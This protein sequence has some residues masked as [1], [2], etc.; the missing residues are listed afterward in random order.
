MPIGY[1]ATVV[2]LTT[3]TLFALIPP[4]PKHSSPSNLSY[5]LGFLINELPFIALFWL[6]FS[7]IL[8]F[9]QGDISSPGSWAVV[10]LAILTTGGLLLIAKRGNQAVPVIKKALNDGLVDGWRSSINDEI[11]SGFRNRRPIG[12]IVFA[13]F[14]VR[15]FRVKRRAN[16]R[17]GDAGKR[18]LLD[19][20][21]HKSTPSKAPV[22]VYLHGGAFRSGRKNREA[23]PLL[24]R[25]ASR[26][27]ICIS[28]NYRLQPKSTFPDHLVDL[29]KVIAWVRKNGHKYGADPTTL[30]VAGSSAGGHLAST[31]GLT[32]NDPIFQPGFEDT[33]TSVTG[34]V[35][36]YGYYGSA[37]ENGIHPSTPL[38]YLKKDA[39][40]F[41]V[42]HG[43]KDTIVIVE[44]ARKF[45]DKLRS[46]SMNPVVYAELPGAQHSFD[47]FHSL[48]FESVVDGVESF[49]AWVRSTEENRKQNVI[50]KS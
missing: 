9:Y 21:H 4:L 36:L 8:A 44:D 12:K 6:I 30:F 45:V 34:V 46:K 16:I 24:Y 3:F 39:P 49:A 22:M 19:L 23:R 1:L 10:G 5:W 17:Y 14:L 40:P 18:N 50:S 35:S 15:N 43:D 11:A 25:L 33:D 31:A 41:F 20:Y 38:A 29:K 27:W 48:R 2:L 26:G 13:P 47:L 42:T 32:Q 28:A 37:R 7:T